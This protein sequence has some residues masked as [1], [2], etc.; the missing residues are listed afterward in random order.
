MSEASPWYK[1]AI[2]YELHIRAFHDSN[3]D[4]TGDFAGLIEKL[5]YLE[6]LGVTAIWI[7]PF[8]PSP[9][10]DD[11]YDI[12]DYEDVHTSYGSL[13]DFKKFLDEAHRR[14]IKVITELVINHTSDQHSWFQKSRRAPKDSYWRN[15]YVWS[16][17]PQKYQDARII[18]K[19]FEPSNWSWDPVA[20]AYY[21][22]R[23][24]SHQPDLNF[25]NPDVQEAIFKVLDYWMEMGVDGLRLDAIPYLF[26]R[27]GTSCENLPETHLFLKKL[28]HHVDTKYPGRMLLAEAN[29]W[30]EDAVGYFG[31]GDECH[32]CFHFPLMPRLF[33]SIKMEDRYSIIDI[34]KQTPEIHESCQWATFLRNHDEL[35]LE[36]VTDEE[37]DYM[38]KVYA[39]D[40]QAAINLGI[41]RRLAPLVSNDRRQIEL[42]NG[43]LFSMPG[44]PVLY[45]GDEIGMGDN[46]YLGDRD[47]VRTPFQWSLDRNAGFSTADPQS[48]YLPL[49]STPEYHYETLNV[50]TAQKNPNSLLWW[51]KKLI[52]I[53][54][55]YSDFSLGKLT[56][57]ESENSKVLSFI[58]SGEKK[59]LVVANLSQTV[60][61]V[62]LDLSTYKG[63]VPLELFGLVSFPAITDRPY[64]LSLN[65]YA[66]YWF[67]LKETNIQSLE[68]N[69]LS[70]P[71][72]LGDGDP[73]GAFSSSHHWR[74]IEK[75]ILDYLPT[76][77]WYLAKDRSLIDCIPVDFIDLKLEDGSL[78]S[79]V[80]ILKLSYREGNPDYYLL[81]VS[82]CTGT[83]A[84]K[85]LSESPG[86]VIASFEK[87][88]TN[89]AGI[90]FESL[91]LPEFGR[92]LIKTFCSDREIK[93][94]FGSIL[95]ELES[96]VEAQSETADLNPNN[97]PL[98][99]A[100]G[101][102]QSNSSFIFGKKYHF[103]LYRKLEYGVHPEISIGRHLLENKIFQKSPHL[104]G[105][106]Y[107]THNR[108]KY[109]I[110]C[111]QN[112]IENQGDGWNLFLN[113]LS[114]TVEQAKATLKSEYQS[115]LPEGG[116][117]NSLLMR[118]PEELQMVAGPTF[119][120]AQLLGQATAEM[121]LA[122]ASGADKPEFGPEPF[123]PFYQRSLYQSFRN[124]MV[125]TLTSLHKALPHMDET[126]KEL[127]SEVLAKENDLYQHFAH[128]KSARIDCARIHIHGDYH[129]GQV[130]YTGKDFYIIDF[131]GEPKKSVSER[132]I[133]RSAL[134]DVAGML[135]SFDYVASYFLKERLLRP[136][137][138]KKVSSFVKNWNWW[139]SSEYVKA[140]LSVANGTPLIPRDPTAFFQLLSVYELEKALYELSYELSSR[141]AWVDIPLVGILKI[142]ETAKT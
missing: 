38:Y 35:T 131:E 42:L 132:N 128:V 26:E 136:E 109:P 2:I 60:Q 9:L 33:M 19:D 115:T 8:Y 48:L 75:K 15:F 56:F 111:L 76:A 20:N 17:T 82:A 141:P 51:T 58:R 142:L 53:R 113:Q 74:L 29:Q 107:Y 67:E 39:S 65:P 88:A 59:I 130:L 7:L 28:R 63:A 140:Y 25:D 44:T 79:R 139:M 50:E 34:L 62:E 127:A 4:G 85:I 13:V 18:F 104:L 66:F 24:Y 3:G 99:Q 106:S 117:K 83:Q 126:V 110:G 121:H 93:G 80:F 64:F 72:R 57:I 134:K 92:E 70:N 30:P 49:I 124:S 31:D 112:Y 103:K 16:E 97:I 100:I 108:K 86:S 95:S 55:S 14:N 61:F 98:P 118:P 54:K 37:R 102:E 41:R 32:M 5:D 133:K 43:L 73:L 81:P 23:F 6:D 89:D 96:S 129:L 137:D 47:G 36:M 90:F 119:T 116:L 40:P 12:S 27:E 138:H 68:V 91:Y 94:E 1:T 21:W 87:G 123:T 52:A 45:Y 22:H 84:E 71:I 46:I 77:R 122:L 114:Q 120:W 105:V 125:K 135:R 69:R 78:L 101:S 10:K 11:G